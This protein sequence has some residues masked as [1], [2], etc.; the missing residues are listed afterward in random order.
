LAKSYE[1]LTER[2]L[3]RLVRDRAFMEIG[4]DSDT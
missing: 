4:N 3:D 1:A 2:Q